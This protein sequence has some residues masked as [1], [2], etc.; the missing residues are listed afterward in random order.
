MSWSHPENCA[1]GETCFPTDLRSGKLLAVLVAELENLDLPTPRRNEHALAFDRGHRA[2]RA[3]DLRKSAMDVFASV[4]QLQLPALER[5]PRGRCRVAAADQVVDQVDMVVPIDSG[6]GRATPS[7]IARLGLVLRAV[8]GTAADHEVCG[9]LQSSDP[10]GKQ[11]IEVQTPERF[12]RIDWGGP[13]KDDRTLIEA[14][15]R[16]KYREAGARV[17]ADDRPI[18]GARPTVPRQK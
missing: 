7:L 9:I 11:A 5:G 16:P 3:L 10:H 12:V 18:D 2:D 1:D 6:L 17:A 13:L 15:A 4:E 8:G 14:V